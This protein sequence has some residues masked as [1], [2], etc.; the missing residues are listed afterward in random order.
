[1]NSDG[2]KGFKHVVRFQTGTEQPTRQVYPISELFADRTRL[3]CPESKRAWRSWT[4]RSNCLFPVQSAISESC[5]SSWRLFRAMVGCCSSDYLGAPI[6]R[7]DASRNNSAVAE[8]ARVESPKTLGSGNF[9]QLPHR[10]SAFQR[11]ELVTFLVQQPHIRDGRNRG[12]ATTQRNRSLLKPWS[13]FWRGQFHGRG[14]VQPSLSPVPKEEYSR[15]RLCTFIG[16]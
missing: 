11:P 4:K 15:R 1:M 9:H 2:H 6:G 3:L 13:R 16:T 7:D 8:K 12:L 5:T 10:T 14:S